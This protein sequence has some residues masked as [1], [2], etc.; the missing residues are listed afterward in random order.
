MDQNFKEA[1]ERDGYMYIKEVPG[2]GVCALRRFVFTVGLIYNITWIGYEGRYCYSQLNHA[3]HALDTWTGDGDP[4][5]DDWIKHKGETE[6]S[7]PLK[8][9]NKTQP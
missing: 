7:N 5:D 2:R 6:Y 8:D 3:V 4:P 1:L 9:E